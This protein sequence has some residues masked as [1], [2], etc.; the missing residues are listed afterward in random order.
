MVF[1]VSMVYQVDQWSVMVMMDTVVGVLCGVM[2]LIS[3]ER[4]IFRR[5]SAILWAD[6]VVRFCCQ[7]LSTD[8]VVRF[9]LLKLSKYFY[10]AVCNTNTRTGVGDL[11]T[12][13]HSLD[14]NQASC[15]C[16]IKEA[17]YQRWPDRRWIA[18]FDSEL[19]PRRPVRRPVSL[20]PSVRSFRQLDSVHLQD[21]K[22]NINIFHA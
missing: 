22:F 7:I 8:F 12:L 18:I 2:C 15:A 20:L 11:S 14:L 16:L 17:P 1:W 5:L 6:F 10:R 13:T 4:Y 3:S 21:Y 9:C 19:H